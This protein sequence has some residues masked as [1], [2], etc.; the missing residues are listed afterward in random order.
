MSMGYS[1]NWT[2][3]IDQDHLHF[4][5]DQ[6]TLTVIEK[7]SREG[8][9]PVTLTLEYG[10]VVELAAA[11]VELPSTVLPRELCELLLS[12]LARYLLGAEGDVV[13]TIN[14]LRLELVQSNQR[15]DNLISGIGRLG[16]ASR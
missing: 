11:D 2:V 16:G 13:A 14:R 4:G 6:L 7:L 8:Y 5:R 9:R 1:E 10:E 3:K 12:A 15:L